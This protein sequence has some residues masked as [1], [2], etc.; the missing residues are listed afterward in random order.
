[1]ADLAEVCVNF[2]RVVSIEEAGHLRVLGIAR[3]GKQRHGNPSLSEP[4]LLP[5]I[6]MVKLGW[7]CSQHCD[8]VMATPL[9]WNHY[10]CLNQNGK[11][12]VELLTAL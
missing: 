8:N 11:T 5:E 4:L 9:F 7:N 2:L 12:G 10:C 1:M 3:P 6:K